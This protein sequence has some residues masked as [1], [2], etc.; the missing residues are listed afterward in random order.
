MRQKRRQKEKR[1]ERKDHG[2]GGT[3]TQRQGESQTIEERDIDTQ[4][5]GGQRPRKRDTEIQREG[6]I[7]SQKL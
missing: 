7:A 3:E 4:R 5:D 2:D 6:D 1:P